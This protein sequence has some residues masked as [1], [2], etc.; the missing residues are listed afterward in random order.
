MGLNWSCTK[1]GWER[2]SDIADPQGRNTILERTPP[3]EVEGERL[4]ALHA[5][6]FELCRR[7]RWE[8]D[9]IE[10]SLTA[11]PLCGEQTGKD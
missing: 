9:Q 3:S 11:D 10:V 4:A 1:C 5:A 2:A 6:E 7:D 8:Q